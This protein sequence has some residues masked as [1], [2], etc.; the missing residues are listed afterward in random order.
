M[1]T[2]ILLAIKNLLKNPI[3]N[4]G[5]HYRSINRVNGMGDALEFYVKDLFC[6]CLNETDLQKKNE[7]Y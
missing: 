1:E 5:S 7:I 6:D 2:N 3:T 4:V